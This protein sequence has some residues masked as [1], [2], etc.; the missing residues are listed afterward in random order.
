MATLTLTD[1]FIRS[2]QPPAAGRDDY[3]DERVPGLSLRVSATGVKSWS[4]RFRDKVTGRI[5]RLTIGRYPAVSLAQ[6]RAVA[7][8]K[9]I[10]IVEGDNP[11][12]IIRRDRAAHASGISFDE[13][14]DRFMEEYVSQKRPK[15]YSSY[16]TALSKA[17]KAWGNWKAREIARDDV[18]DLTERLAVAAPV[19]TNR[20]LSVLSKMFNWALDLR[21]PP[22]SSSPVA[23]VP[24]PGIER[25]R[26]RVL[27]DDEIAV[28]WAAWQAQC[29]PEVARVFMTLLLTGQRLS[30]VVH[31][32]R[33]ELLDLHSMRLARWHL[34]AD[35]VKNSRGHIVPLSPQAVAIIKAAISAGGDDTTAVFASR[36]NPGQHF[37]RQSFARAMKRVVTGLELDGPD[38]KTIRRIQ[39][40]P[41]T[42]HDLRR[43]V[44][45]G[46]GML[47]TRREVIKAVLNH[48]ERDVTAVYALHDYLD[49]KREALCLWAD[50]VEKLTRPVA[51]DNVLVM[52]GR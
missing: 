14:A 46:L 12:D 3:V 7:T 19:G 51:G 52:R 8:K 36:R 22:V 35:R 49:D 33:D 29:A 48:M 16:K 32:E 45:T 2:V 10:G 41:P 37:D 24:K 15:S 1:T 50:H 4:L 43:T 21:D 26:D 40:D 39:G 30:E 38:Q 27:R 28:L 6:A 47:G 42:P 18:M 34:P 13:L 5:E 9:V 25:A 11:Q 44:G 20:M 31:M 23:R 17:R